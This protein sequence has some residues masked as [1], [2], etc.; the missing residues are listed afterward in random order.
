MARPSCV[1]PALVVLLAIFL[2]VPAAAQD[3]PP[4]DGSTGT[5]TGAPAPEPLPS[6]TP[7]QA[8][9]LRTILRAIHAAQRDTAAALGMTHAAATSESTIGV[10]DT[11]TDDDLRPMWPTKPHLESLL[12]AVESQRDSLARAG[13]SLLEL[14]VVAKTAGLPDPDYSAVCAGYQSDPDA[15]F[16]AMLVYNIAKTAAEVAEDACDQVA[17]ALGFGGNARLACIVTDVAMGVAELVFWGLEFCDNDTAGAR[18]D[19]V[20]ERTEHIHED[21]EAMQEDI[22]FIVKMLTCRPIVP[23]TKM[24]GCN[25]A[26][27]DCDDPPVKDECDEDIFGPDVSIAGSVTVPWFRSKTEANLAVQLATVAV[28]ACSGVTVDLPVLTGTCDQVLASVTARDRCGNATTVTALV[29]MDDTPPVV[30]IPPSMSGRCFSTQREAEAAILAA[31]TV[32][33]GCT[34]PGLSKVELDSS[35]GDCNLRVRVTATDLSGLSSSDATTVRIDPRPPEI[36]IDPAVSIPWY[37][38]VGE[39]QSAVT[40]A[41]RITDNCEL[42]SFSDV[43]MTG[44]CGV[45]NATVTATDAC[46]N[47]MSGQTVVKVDGLPPVVAIAPQVSGQC[48]ASID[49]AETAVRA[50]TSISDNCSMLADLEIVVRSSVSDCNLRVTVQATD[51]AGLSSSASVTV[52]VDSQSP[53]LRIDRAAL[54]FK[55]APLGAP[56]PCFATTAAAEAAVRDALLA[57]DNCISSSAITTTITSTGPSCSLLVTARATDGCGATA[58]D[59]V[60]LRVDATPPVVTCTVAVPTLMHTTARLMTDVGF[61]FSATDGCGPVTTAIT[62]TSD[63]NT[64]AGGT[65][66]AP[67]AEILRDATGLFRGVRLRAERSDAG[68]GRVYMI[69]VTATDACGNVGQSSC[70]V[71]VPNGTR[72]ID[73]GQYFDATG[74]N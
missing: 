69:K 46:G 9:E 36:T 30:T 16:A 4:D 10:V 50:A 68:D 59:A 64:W 66:P 13:V 24:S 41:I 57:S 35:V 31:T 2:S 21:L 8:E 44:S 49:A 70:F 12:D 14:R 38:S 53:T 32:T 22:D 48:F 25:G 18:A 47:T 58:S 28:D 56:S 55:G 72:Q 65:S 34:P 54:G 63:E 1:S 74:I 73:S 7:E 43:T 23:L 45:V 67:D 6:L 19:A 5:E 40:R 62:V 39:A 71:R 27:D 15:L 26:D 20:F 29:K 33:D 60:V 61:N 17:V 52:R 37:R 3:D 11:M 51:R 42:R